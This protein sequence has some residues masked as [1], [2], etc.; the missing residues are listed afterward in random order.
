MGT[1]T[2]LASTLTAKYFPS[3]TLT[4]AFY[5]DGRLFGKRETRQAD[6]TIDKEERGFFLSVFAHPK[7]PEYEPGMMPP[8]EP[9]LRGT[10]NEVKFGRK[11]IDGMIEGFLSTAV[12]VTGKMRLQDSDQ[13]SPYF[14]GVIVRDAEAFAVTIGSGLAFLYR[15]DTLFPLTDAGIPMEPI[16]SDGNRV[17]DFNYYC[18]S[19]TANALWSNFFTLSPDDCIILCNKEVYDALGQRELLRILAEAEDQCD[20][21]GVVITQASARMPN[22]AMQFSISF[23]ESVTSDEKRGLFGF[24]KKNKEED[25]SEMSIK[26]TLEGG[27]VGAAAESAADAGFTA[28]LPMT[29]SPA[30]KEAGGSIVFGD[31]KPGVA[32]PSQNQPASS[33]N[34]FVVMGQPEVKKADTIKGIEFLDTSIDKPSGE[35]TPEEV[36]R[37]LMNEG[38]KT[39]AS[40]AAAAASGA[41]AQTASAGAAAGTAAAAAAAAS[42]FVASFNPFEGA[43]ESKP[44]SD[45]PKMET[46]SSTP[47]SFVDDGDASKT[48]PVLKLDLSALEK[49][50]EEA[51]KNGAASDVEGT[52]GKDILEDAVKELEGKMDNTDKEKESEEKIVFASEGEGI[53]LDDEK[54]AARADFDPYSVGSA[55]EMQNA[56]PIVFGDDATMAAAKDVTED[57]AEDDGIPVPEFEIKADKPELDDKDKLGVDFPVTAASEA[58]SE[59]TAA[60]A[61]PA[62]EDAGFTL[63]FGNAVDVIPEE[64][65][66]PAKQDDIPDMPV[67]D[68]NTFDTPAQ[69][70]PAAA[71]DVYSY[72]QYMENENMASRVHEPQEDIADIPPYQPYGGEGMNY[73]PNAGYTPDYQ[74][75][76]YQPQPQDYAADAYQA[77]AAA[78]QDPYAAPSVDNDWIDSILG[79]DNEAAADPYDTAAQAPRAQSSGSAPVYGQGGPRTSQAPR[80]PSSSASAGSSG[81]GISIGGKKIK[82]N[83]NGYIFLAFVIICLVLLIVLIS[84]IV[85]GCKKDDAEVTDPD[86]QTE[87]SEETNETEDPG[88]TPAETSEPIQT[89]VVNPSAPIGRFHFSTHDGFRTWY[90]L[91]RQVYNVEIG[92][93]DDSRVATIIS[94]NGLP[95]D[96]T[97]SPEDAILLPPPGVLDGTIENTFVPGGVSA[98]AESGVSGL[99]QLTDGSTDET[100]ADAGEGGEAGET[101][102]ADAGEAGEEPAA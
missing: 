35:M 33:D 4:D 76:Q 14:S 39:A 50:K 59:E 23:V 15:D 2:R 69:A 57:K 11:E 12:D 89:A 91:F 55:E 45:E 72:G 94:Y 30:M 67:Y 99:P 53:T 21:A 93:E 7:I 54:A 29:D 92:S 97:P 43:S 68:G 9:Q 56:A 79:I 10:C 62:S 13:R 100:A 46:V 63:P 3:Q 95:E 80:T 1:L 58:K 61:A 86:T 73:D 52:S 66:A 18:S 16:D 87:Q 74:P 78:P 47:F 40:G 101:E 90:D 37:S 25:T 38:A 20:A 24:R 49:F 34:G 36:M 84:A 51:A 71:D 22:T 42:P 17:A 41:A 75:G 32:A 77:Q 81:G 88:K 60:E 48:K 82:I 8:Y 19:K 83:R 6:I 44:A 5:I 102:A 98:P 96:Y 28:G 27:V 31:S 70:E 64:P 85:K 26:S 65:A